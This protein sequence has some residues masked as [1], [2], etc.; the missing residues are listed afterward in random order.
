MTRYLLDT[1]VLIDYLNGRPHVVDAIKRL[2]QEGHI[3][4]VCCI[5]VT[6]LYAGLRENEKPAAEKLIENLTY[7]Q[8]TPEVA[9]KAREYIYGFARKGI[10]LGTSNVT[11]AAVAIANHAIFVTANVHHYPIPNVQLMEL[12]TRAE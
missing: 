12:P 8:V 7:F 6:E 5:K 10:I 3:L 2:A 4:G 9:R 1:T 11:I